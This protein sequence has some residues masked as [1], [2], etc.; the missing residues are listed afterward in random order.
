MIIEASD[1][2][3]PIRKR[4]DKSALPSVTPENFVFSQKNC[5]TVKELWLKMKRMEKSNSKFTK[6]ISVSKRGEEEIQLC[7]PKECREE[8][9]NI[10]HSSVTGHLGLTKNK[11]RVL[12]KI[13]WHN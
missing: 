9:L 10:C 2:I 4:L 7:L 12:A 3:I 13:F 6:R 5:P 1:T 8:I 11:D